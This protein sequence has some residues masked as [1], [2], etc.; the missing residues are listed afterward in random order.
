MS[1]EVEAW[2]TFFRVGVVILVLSIV[3]LGAMLYQEF[4]LHIHVQ[5]ATITK[6]VNTT[7]CEL[8]EELIKQAVATTMDVVLVCLLVVLFVA[9]LLVLLRDKLKSN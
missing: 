8:V 6:C 5:P 2:E 4:V 3:V 1:Q 9:S 7:Q